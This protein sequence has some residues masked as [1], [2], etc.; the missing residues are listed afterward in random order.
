MTD[1]LKLEHT[2]KLVTLKED[3]QRETGE[4]LALERKIE[5]LKSDISRLRAEQRA[6]IVH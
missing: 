5:E 3:L 2:P 6:S 4:V 1:G